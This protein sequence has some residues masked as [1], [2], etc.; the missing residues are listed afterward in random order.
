MSSTLL[1][2]SASPSP[3]AL[4]RGGEPTR[5]T[6]TP[7][8]A[9]AVVAGFVALSLSSAFA[10]A[11]ATEQPAAPGAAHSQSAVVR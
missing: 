2:P 1:L 9:L 4:D 5:V 11:G 6:T 10:S 7:G 3:A 8:L